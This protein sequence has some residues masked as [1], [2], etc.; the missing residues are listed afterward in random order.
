MSP[1]VS[2]LMSVYNGESFLAEAIQSILDQTYTD[3]EFLIVND[4]STDGTAGILASFRD[5][6]IKIIYLEKQSG[7]VYALNIGIEQCQGE[8]IA[9]MDAD[10]R[11]M[12][13]RFEKQVHF[14]DK[15]P[16]VGVCGSW[17]RFIGIKTGNFK[18]PVT[19]EEI[20]VNLIRQWVIVH[21]SVM[22][23]RNVLVGHQMRYCS[24]FTHLEDKE[25]WS[26]LIFLT[27]FH[28]LPEYL[29]EYRQH[30][31]QITRSHGERM[32]HLN[33][34]VRTRLLKHLDP[35]LDATLETNPTIR[36]IVEN[37]PFEPADLLR[38]GFDWFDHLRSVNQRTTV[39]Y[40]ES[41]K[42]TLQMWQSD[43]VH[44][45][46]FRKAF[47]SLTDLRDYCFDSAKPFFS[48][49]LV[50]HLKFIMKCVLGWK[51]RPTPNS[52]MK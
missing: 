40:P 36:R 31:G 2:V 9:R 48:T 46:Y 27:R 6:R 25:L 28:N 45:K 5:P 7:L 47:Y 50:V 52:K 1:R 8:F 4:G 26:R 33:Y 41:F 32:R 51:Q 13:M 35:S 39:F 18:A 10:D 43:L 22:L 19:H 24:D 12:P 29:L 21:P 49:G 17:A 34:K 37:R 42:R 30:A 15:N 11:S 38:T 44:R 23:R 16:Q 14:F 3:F 20:I